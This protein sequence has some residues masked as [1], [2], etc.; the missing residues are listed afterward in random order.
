MCALKCEC[1]ILFTTYY[2]LTP[3]RTMVNTIIYN[4]AITR[5]IT[6]VND[7]VDQCRY[8]CY[9]LLFSLYRIRDIVTAT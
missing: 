3:P 1:D 7:N 8:S 6:E 5:V 4:I 9:S 2:H